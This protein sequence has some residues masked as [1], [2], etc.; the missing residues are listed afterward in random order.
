M[1]QDEINHT[2]SQLGDTQAAAALNSSWNTLNNSA[3]TVS[4][5][6][7]VSVVFFNKNRGSG[8][9]SLYRSRF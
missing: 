5:L 4:D 8:S 6:R 7:S 2:M 9:I 3:V 1:P